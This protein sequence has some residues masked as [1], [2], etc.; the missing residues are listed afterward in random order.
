MI[1][2]YIDDPT[3]LEYNV[4]VER[5]TPHIMRIYGTEANTSGFTLSREGMNDNW[6]YS[7][8]VTVYSIGENYIEY[9]NNRTTLIVNEPEAIS[10]NVVINDKINE[11]NEIQ[12]QTIEDGVDVTF[13]D[14]T[15]EHFTL[16]ANDQLSLMQLQALAMQGVE[17][18]PWHNSNKEDGCKYYTLEEFSLI[19]NTVIP[20]VTYHVT[21]FRDLRRY[22]MSLE[23]LTDINKVTYGMAIPEAYQ[24]DV[25]KAILAG[26]S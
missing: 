1:L 5:V 20:F 10:I 17:Y 14:G 13:K 3:G 2:K 26:E 25:L 21:Y 12:Q 7:K 19:S 8:F 4:D 16:T 22:V 9:S 23:H 6:D 18:I 24:S 11:L 15:V